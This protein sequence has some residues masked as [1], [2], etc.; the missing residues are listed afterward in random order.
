MGRFID[1][2]GK[3][4]GRLTVIRRVENKGDAIMYS[5]SCSC[6]NTKDVASSNLKSGKIKSCGCIKREMLV[7]KNKSNATHNMTNTKLF[8]VW[9]S[10][11]KRASINRK[12]SFNNKNYGGRGIVLCEEWDS[13]FENFYSWSIANGYREGLQIDRIDNDSGYRPDNCRWVTSFKNNMNKRTN[14]DEDKMKE[15]IIMY[16]NGMK[17]SEIS[18][19]LDMS[20]HGLYQRLTGRRGV[21]R[22]PKSLDKF[23]AIKGK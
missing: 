8:K 21:E 11:K 15:A 16:N 2:T 10:I 3:E 20:Y 12:S 18:R 22:I 19:L 13:S 7:A 6:G 23:T 4:F 14:L 17:I 5:C 9:D 1:L